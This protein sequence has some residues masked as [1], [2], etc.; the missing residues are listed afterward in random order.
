MYIYICLYNNLIKC[1]FI[2]LI[3]SKID[4]IIINC[5]KLNKRKIILKIRDDFSS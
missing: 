2:Y 5:Q 4:W 1:Y 3:I